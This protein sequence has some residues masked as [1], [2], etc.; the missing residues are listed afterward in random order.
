MIKIREFNNINH[1]YACK[2]FNKIEVNKSEQEIQSLSLEIEILKKIDH[3][4][5]I[6][7]HQVYES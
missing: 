5:I 3:P 7:L 2:I 6:K 4:N 1:R